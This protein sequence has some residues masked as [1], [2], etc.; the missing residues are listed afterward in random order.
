G[1]TGPQRLV[2]RIVKTHPGISAGELA[3]VA[4]LH[5]STITGI[6]Q[7]LVKKGLVSAERDSGDNRRVRLHLRPEGRPYARGMK[8]TVEAAVKR[9]LDQI[10]KQ[11]LL[12]TRAVLAALATALE[13]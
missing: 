3:R 8:G 1:I 10:P 6:V 9:T 13:T 4:R 7:R 12:Q 2:L 5:P 11:Q